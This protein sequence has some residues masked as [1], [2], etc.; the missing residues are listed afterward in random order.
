MGRILGVVSTYREGG[1]LMSNG[2]ERS[3]Y[4]RTPES[5]VQEEKEFCGPYAIR[6]GTKQKI[7]QKKGKGLLLRRE[8][9]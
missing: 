7:L 6:E 3:C 2:P 9:K 4:S 5:S 8:K 1:L